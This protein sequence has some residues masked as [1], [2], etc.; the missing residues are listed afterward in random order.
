MPSFPV[1]FT[2]IHSSKDTGCYYY[3]DEKICAKDRCNCTLIMIYD[4]EPYRN[5]VKSLMITNV[6]DDSIVLEVPTNSLSSGTIQ[7]L[8][9]EIVDYIYIEYGIRNAV[10]AMLAT[11]W[12]TYTSVGCIYVDN[13]FWTIAVDGDASA[14]TVEYKNQLY[15]CSFVSRMAGDCRSK[16]YLVSNIT[17]KLNL[18]S[19]FYPTIPIMM[20]N[21]KLCGLCYDASQHCLAIRNIITR[22]RK[23]ISEIDNFGYKGLDYLIK[24]NEQSKYG[25][26][27]FSDD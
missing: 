12:E 24:G 11:N 6:R 18:E 17:D 9:Y 10:Y 1:P 20:N 23:K 22:S 13:R 2:K 27:I 26:E 16:T 25:S 21:C 15:L 5:D 4:L 19:T 3:I 14:C 7:E 8:V